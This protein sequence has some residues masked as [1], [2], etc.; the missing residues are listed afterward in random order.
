MSD[1]YQTSPS[2][3]TALAAT[4]GL[5]NC[6]GWGIR[7]EFGG[8]LGAMPC[9]ALTAYALAAASGNPR[10]RARAAQMAA[11]GAFAFSFGGAETYG[12][13]LGLSQHPDLRQQYYWWGILGCA[14]KGAA[15][16]GLGGG[17]M[18]MALAN[19][20]HRPLEVLAL[21]GAM[22]GLFRLGV[23]LLNKPMDPPDHLPRI[24]F[25][26]FHHPADPRD[27]PRREV[28]G[29][30]WLGLA[31]LM[32]YLALKRDWPT[33]RMAVSGIAG[34]ATGF[35]GG[36]AI[37]A[38]G[39]VPGR[40]SDRT[41]QL[42]NWWKAMEMSFGLIG[43]TVLGAGFPNRAGEPEPL[44]EADRVAGGLAGL[45]CAGILALAVSGRKWAE[46]LIEHP[47]AWGCAGMAACLAD[48]RYAWGLLLPGELLV[49]VAD[50]AEHWRREPGRE[51]QVRALWGAFLPIAV[52]ETAWAW[53]LGSKPDRAERQFPV[54]LAALT[55]GLVSMA[56]LKSLTRSPRTPQ[57]KGEGWLA[58]QWR[59]R[60][61][62]V[63]I[64]GA[65]VL[66]GA[67]LTVAATRRE[68]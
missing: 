51:G 44:S 67:A 57:A 30:L 16:F 28:W 54:A 26:N 53:R 58:R 13:T 11:I 15:W 6:L 50:V 21:G 18:G 17:F 39:R 45:A 20:R 61:A 8:E 7:G 29:G 22:T 34:G 35:A 32:A 47:F 60:P 48:E 52:A 23:E 2:E 1:R 46:S 64:Q 14:I 9:G 38:G 37:Q 24:Y 66:L 31:G 27:R 68:T 55:W 33:L 19:R 65:F 3:R 56:G 5:A 36:Q 43:S 62:S 59:E 10:V 25:S 4:A 49:H 12:Q 40:F 42:I 63:L 41:H